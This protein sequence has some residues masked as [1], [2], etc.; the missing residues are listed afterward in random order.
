MLQKEHGYCMFSTLKLHNRQHY[1]HIREF[2]QNAFNSEE[3]SEKN[4]IVM[5]IN[6]WYEFEYKI[7]T[8]NLI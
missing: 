6:T 2:K 3:S 1:V 5:A 8:F 7:F 4:G